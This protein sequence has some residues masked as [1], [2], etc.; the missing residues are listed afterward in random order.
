MRW[1]IFLCGLLIGS[2]GTFA[3]TRLETPKGNPLDGSLIVFAAKFFADGKKWHQDEFVTISGTLTGD[4]MAYPN[5]TYNVGCYRD[6][7]ECVVASVEQIGRNQIGRMEVPLIFPII[8][9]GEYEIVAADEPS[10]IQCAKATITIERDEG[11]LLW[12]EEP[13]NQTRP[14]CK[15]ADTKLVKYTMES[16]P[17]WTK[18]FG[19]K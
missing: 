9:W 15:Y 19:E 1:V 10:E 18:V 7:N 4:G 16:S 17:A 8:K 6:R 14:F 5:N 12:V 2:G 3:A 13:I 11:S